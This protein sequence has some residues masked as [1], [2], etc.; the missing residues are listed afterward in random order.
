L[1]VAQVDDERVE[2]FGQASGRG[3]AAGSVEPVDE[4][5]IGTLRRRDALVCLGPQAELSV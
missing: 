1:G 4:A 5:W 2:I 3:G